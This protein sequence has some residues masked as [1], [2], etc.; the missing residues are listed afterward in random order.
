MKPVVLIGISV[1][2][3]IWLWLAW[4]LLT[5]AGFNLKN[6]IIL[7]MSAIIVFVPLWKKISNGK[8]NEKK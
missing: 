8:Q 7:S 1:L 3:L 6:L 5:T 4:L 2:I